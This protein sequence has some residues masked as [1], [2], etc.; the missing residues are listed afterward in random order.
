[1]LSIYPG[2]VAQSTQNSQSVNPL[3][4]LIH[5]IPRNLSFNLSIG[6]KIMNWGLIRTAKF[7]TKNDIVRLLSDGSKV[8]KHLFFRLKERYSANG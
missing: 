2:S 3:N 1:M 6:E 5:L 7:V 4:H 8:T